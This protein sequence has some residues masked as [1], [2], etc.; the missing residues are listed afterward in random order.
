MRLQRSHK[1]TPLIA[2]V[3]EG[4]AC[5]WAEEGSTPVAWGRRPPRTSRSPVPRRGALR[6]HGLPPPAPRA[7]DPRALRAQ[8]RRYDSPQVRVP[9]FP[10]PCFFKALVGGV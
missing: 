6:S 5:Q 9:S 3:T 4:H 7:P 2:G 8:P 1:I 10:I